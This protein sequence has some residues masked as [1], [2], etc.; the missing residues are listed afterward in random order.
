MTDK[1]FDLHTVRCYIKHRKRAADKRF[2]LIVIGS[3]ENRHLLEWRFFLIRTVIVKHKMYTV[4]VTGIRSP[5]SA[6]DRRSKTLGVDEPPTVMAALLL[7][8]Q[9]Y[10]I[11]IIL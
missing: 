7:S 3:I 6:S 11:I 9:A 10:C 5:L 1:L 2:V 8:K 4:I